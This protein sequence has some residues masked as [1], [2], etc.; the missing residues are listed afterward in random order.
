M[1]VFR[2][3]LQNLLRTVH[4][5]SFQSPC[6]IHAIHL[7]AA[8]IAVARANHTKHN[9]PNDMLPLLN[10]NCGANPE[11]NATVCLNVGSAVVPHQHVG[12][13]FI[14]C[15]YSSVSRCNRGAEG[16]PPTLSDSAGTISELMRLETTAA[17][18][19]ATQQATTGEHQQTPKTLRLRKHQR[20][21]QHQ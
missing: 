1:K 18:V 2:L 11:P 6:G 21:W 10:V 3:P 5:P 14:M 16:K 4:V 15:Y 9:P 19:K 7:S 20:R 8:K 12:N 17:E 13:T